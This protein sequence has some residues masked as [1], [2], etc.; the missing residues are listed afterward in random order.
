VGEL[1][2]VAA[3]RCLVRWC[4]M[5]TPIVFYKELPRRGH[6]AAGGPISGQREGAAAEATERSTYLL[7]KSSYVFKTAHQGVVVSDDN[8]VEG[9]RQSG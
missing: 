1:Q 2:A 9:S 5:G 3:D 7:A 4:E 6:V 8:L